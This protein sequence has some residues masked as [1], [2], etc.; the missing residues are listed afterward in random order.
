MPACDQKTA[1]TDCLHCCKS[2]FCRD[3]DTVPQQHKDI[4]NIGSEQTLQRMRIRCPLRK[5]AKRQK[6]RKIVQISGKLFER[7]LGN[8]AHLSDATSKYNA[9]R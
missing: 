8:Y 4:R 6:R 7:I 1:R 3:Q 5:I 9:G 2:P